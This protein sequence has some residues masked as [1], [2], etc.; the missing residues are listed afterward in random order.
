MLLRFVKTLRR[1]AV[2]F[3]GTAFMLLPIS[4]H[5]QELDAPQ[6]PAQFDPSDVY[7]QG[8]L[9]AR[10]AE[11]LERDGDYT[12]AWEK[13]NQA[14]K[15]F[16]SVR[17][18][19][20]N[21]KPEMVKGRAEKTAEGLTSVKPKAEE[22][23]RKQS[24]AIAEL[25]GGARTKGRDIDPK[26]GV[27]PLTPGILEVDPLTSRRLGEAEAEVKRLRQALSD[28][29]SS[30]SDASRGASR[31]RDMER[32]RD[33]AEAQLKAAEAT[34]QQ[35]RSKLAGSPVESEMKALN[36]RI[37]KLEQEKSAMAMALSQSRSE[38]IDQEAKIALLETDLKLMKQKVGELRQQNAN[39]DRDL[40]TQQDVANKVVAG[41]RRQ[42]EQLEKQ[43]DLKN[44]EL[45]TAH[46]QISGL[47]R[48][49]EESQD[50]F[51]QLRT[52]RDALVQERDQMSAL[53]KL[54]EGGRIQQLVEQNMALA[55]NLREANEK[56]DRLNLD[57]N[58]TK[59]D[60][61]DALRDLAM[62]KSQINRLFQE[63]RDQ[64]KRLA[65]LES[66]LKGEE[67]ALASG[68]ASADPAEIETLREII[69]RQ[70]RSQERRKQARDL[71]VEAA[72]QMGGKDERIAQAVELFDGQ[73]IQLSP[74][75][76]KLIA[77]QQVNG[78]FVSPVVRDRGFVNRATAALNTEL[79]GYD[80]AAEK[81]FLSGRLLPTREL[82]QMIIDANPGNTS[83]LCKLGVVNLRLKDTQA[84]IDTF[85]RAVEMDDKNAYAQ[86]MLG[87]AL[88]SAGD[89]QA[90]EEHIRKA[91]EIAPEDA[92]SQMLMGSLCYRGGRVKEAESHFKAAITADPVLS[93]PYF[94]L[95]WI[96]A[97][98]NRVE[99]ARSYYQQALER[100][101]VP[102]PAL[103][104]WLDSAP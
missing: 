37:E 94:N 90:A 16:Q 9:A 73:E 26:Q 5:A 84:A 100:G 32:Q 52:E 45:A 104:Q 19:Y 30:Q 102:D 60:M 77:S 18:Y 27:Q 28:S 10:A 48:Q 22:Q 14:N 13:L 6:Q 76:Q 99:E 65:E 82:Y 86:R 87:F 64:E 95:A 101:A 41:Q 34:V 89:T 81:A 88:D 68:A 12:G 35:L 2:T 53:L 46:Q 49:L 43:L 4:I 38:K 83:A 85:R 80:R 72:K 54:N 62:A 33:L 74:E 24:G 25:E 3:A 57:N 23:Q 17:Q 44:T 75:E 78:E 15:L 103:E 66:R 93:E 92:K 63:K 7:F 36:G 31:M 61:T 21:W 8:Y 58:A 1:P 70:L 47:K 39:Q 97:R 96:Y 42:I 79:E 40:K 71:L 51:T 67:T 20:P 11:Q 69:R 91:V 50:T 29:Q 56:V 98:G 59:D 55:K